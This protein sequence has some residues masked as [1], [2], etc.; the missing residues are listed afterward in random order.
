MTLSTGMSDEGVQVWYTYCHVICAGTVDDQ[1]GW[2]ADELMR[3]G[4][5]LDYFRSV[6]ENDFYPHFI[7]NLD[8][9][10][11][12]GGCIPPIHVQADLRDT[13]LLGLQW[14]WEGGGMLVR[15]DDDIHRMTDL[16]G[17][18][19]GISRSLNPVKSDYRR[20]TEERGIESMLLLNGMSRDDVEIVD[21]P[22]ADDWYDGP[23][24]EAPQVRLAELWRLR[25]VQKD[26]KHRPL[27][28]QLEAG[29]IDACFVTD[30]FDTKYM[31]SG[32]SKLIESLYRYPDWT[33]HVTNT[34][35]A[36]TC[37]RTFADQH[38]ELVT[39]Y[40]KGM[41]RVGRWCNADRWA[42]A[43]LLE[44]TDFY[45]PREVTYE[46]IKRVD[47]VPNLSP[48]NLKAVGIEKDFMLSHGYIKNDFDVGEWAAPEFLEA[49]SRELREEASTP[50]TAE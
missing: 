4:A 35:W 48:M 49:A 36:L 44:K 21:C 33:H 34:P 5:R 20:I 38:P 45:P 31:E 46:S 40:L 29:V 9:L 12:F 30:P 15:S 17:R 7:H 11:R 28:A 26:L 13:L 25:D 19:I 22:F 23:E 6:P 18:R 39:A 14:F 50:P 24:M 42:A 37:T 16:R 2:T 10:F 1:L 47:F 3:H 41:V 27:E 32:T 43:E 8:G